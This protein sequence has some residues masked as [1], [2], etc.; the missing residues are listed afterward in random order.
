METMI[1]NGITLIDFLYYAAVFL[2]S[3]ILFYNS[4]QHATTLNRMLYRLWMVLFLVLCGLA[5]FFQRPLATRLYVTLLLV[6]SLVLQLTI[7]RR[8]QHLSQ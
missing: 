2:L 5:Y 4:R 8:A 3:I 7:W 6:S 1:A